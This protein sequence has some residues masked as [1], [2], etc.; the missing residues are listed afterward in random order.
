MYSFI[1]ES[2]RENYW[3][4]DKSLNEKGYHLIF[5]MNCF[6]LARELEGVVK[7][8]QVVFSPFPSSSKKPE[9]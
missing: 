7:Q 4:S 2:F 3:N 8:I 1:S 6:A 5:N 9:K